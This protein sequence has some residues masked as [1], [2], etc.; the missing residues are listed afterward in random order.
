MVR[1]WNIEGPD[2]PTQMTLGKAPSIATGGRVKSPETYEDPVGSVAKCYTGRR[3][4]A[5]GA[6]EVQFI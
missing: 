5:R 2:S 6:R 4:A 1:S 3:V